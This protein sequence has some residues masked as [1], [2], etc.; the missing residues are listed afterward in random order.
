[1]MM[2]CQGKNN[3]NFYVS[4]GE[5]KFSP[6]LFPKSLLP[7]WWLTSAAKVTLGAGA[8]V[9]VSLDRSLSSSA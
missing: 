3:S 8:T 7:F 9:G 4:Y 5:S 1:M 6:N 2:I